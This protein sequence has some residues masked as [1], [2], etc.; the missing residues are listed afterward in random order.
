MPL[1]DPRLAADEVRRCAAK[2]SH[3]VAFSENP[4]KLKLPSIHTTHWDPLFAACEETDSVVNLHIGSSSTFPVTS[5]DAPRAVSL[6]LTYQ[7]AAHAFADWLT[8]G[9]LERFSTLRVALSEGQIGWMP[10]LL[11]RLD[12]VWHE[13]PVY[14]DVQHLSRPPSSYL[15]GRVYG[16]VFDDSVGL[17]LRERIGMSQIMFE[18]DYPHGDSTWPNTRTVF[19][20][21]VAEAGLSDREAY[22]F[23]RGNAITC[24]GLGRY[25]ITE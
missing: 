5:R 4:T 7:G 3:A 12:S 6:A 8:C 24:Y 23:A 11:E 16:C 21:I 18:V 14:G 25:G 15:A 2:G 17:A 19:E 9:V 13:R 22:L 20:K 1:W 10:F